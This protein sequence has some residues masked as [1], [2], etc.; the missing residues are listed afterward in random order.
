MFPARTETSQRPAAVIR[1]GHGDHSRRWAKRAGLVAL[2]FGVAFAL[3]MATGQRYSQVLGSIAIV[4]SLLGVWP[5]ART[6][7]VPVA[8]YTGVW[9][10]FNVLRAFGDEVSWRHRWL[11][12]VPELEARI[13]GGELPS[14]WVQRQWFD[15][16]RVDLFDQFWTVVYLSYFIVPHAV[17]IILL[18][19]NR[20]LS[21]RYVAATAMLFLIGIVAFAALPT[22]PPWLPSPNDAGGSVMRVINIVLADAGLRNALP[23]GGGAMAQHHSFEPNPVATIPSIH[24]G[25]TALLVPL[26]TTSGWRIVALLYTAAMGFS[27]VYLGEHYVL[28]AVAGA[29]AAAIAWEV[30][31]RLLARRSENRTPE[32]VSLGAAYPVNRR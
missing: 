23:A 18:L 2:T 25:V 26:A 14:T 17:A 24:L 32:G 7:A 29:I 28:D 13:L 22:N 8:A 27:L 12:V 30:V 3:D 16:A 1:G 6:V 31:R 9:A 5:R 19:R 11:H 21:W 20:H 10:A 15:P 4:I